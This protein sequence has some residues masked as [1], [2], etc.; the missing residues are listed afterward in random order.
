LQVTAL[1]LAGTGT[2]QELA[3]V[4][5]NWQPHRCRSSRKSP[6]HVDLAEL[7]GEPAGART[8]DHLIKSLLAKP[9]FV[10]KS[11][12]KVPN[13]RAGHALKAALKI[14]IWEP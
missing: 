8:R 5:Q 6:K 14:G 12:R 10:E 9:F 3:T 13:C 1:R 4:T 2:E 11:M 7:F